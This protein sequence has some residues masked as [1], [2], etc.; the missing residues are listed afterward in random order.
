MNKDTYYKGK[1][2]DD[3]KSGKGEFHW[4]SG[5]VYRGHFKND[6]WHGYGDMWWIDGSYYKG[7]WNKGVQHGEGEM[8]ILEN[9]VKKVK[10]GKFWKN[11]FI[12][13]LQEVPEMPEPNEVDEAWMST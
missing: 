13:T 9:G 5:N 6:K 12:D 11:V 10:R 3:L 4:A 7:Q 1:Y 8:S 2:K